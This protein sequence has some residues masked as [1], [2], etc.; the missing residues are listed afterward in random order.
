MDGIGGMAAEE[1]VVDVYHR[2]R[3]FRDDACVLSRA[4]EKLLC[5]LVG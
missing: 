3:V 4:E 5:W 1:A 2:L